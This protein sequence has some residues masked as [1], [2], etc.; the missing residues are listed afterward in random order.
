LFR[1]E[2]R[3]LLTEISVEFPSVHLLDEI[4]NKLV[5]LPKH[6]SLVSANG[7]GAELTSAALGL[8]NQNTTL[9]AAETSAG[10][11]A[12]YEKAT[13]KGIASG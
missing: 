3:N 6:A 7:K 10:Q 2:F 11:N 5:S 12:G 13:L 4:L 9:S 1:G 8:A